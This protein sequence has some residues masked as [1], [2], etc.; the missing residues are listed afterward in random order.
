MP[1]LSLVL[2][3]LP[4]NAFVCYSYLFFQWKRIHLYL[5]GCKIICF[6]EDLSLVLSEPRDCGGSGIN[7]LAFMIKS[8]LGCSFFGLSHFFFSY[9]NARM[10]FYMSWFFIILE[11]TFCSISL[12]CFNYAII[13]RIS[14]V[15]SSCVH[16]TMQN[17]NFSKEVIV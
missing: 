8:Y 14:F 15:S 2:S 3:Q 16:N 10:C 5:W 12:F 1:L 6:P 7:L 9:F 4:L 11:P 13:L 17:I